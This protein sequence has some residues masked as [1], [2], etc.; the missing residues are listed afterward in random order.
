MNSII[1]TGASSMIGAATVAEALKQNIQVT[2]VIRK[3]S[4]QL[5]NL[6]HLLTDKNID[7]IE[8][9][10]QNY[11]SLSFDKK[12][13]AFFH[14]AWQSTSFERRDDVYTQI[15]NIKF[16]MDALNTAKRAGCET[17]V[18]TG[19]QAEYGRV[20][21]KLG[22]DTKCNPES[23]YGIA[24]YAAGKMSRLLASQSGIRLCYARVLSVYGEGMLSGTFIMYLIKTLLGGEKP[25][26]TKCEQLWDYMYVRDAARALLSIAEKGIDGRVYPIGSGNARPL[27]E[28]AEIIRDIINPSS[29]LGFGEK[30][31]YP[32]QPMYLCADINSLK[33]DTGFKP[34]YSFENGIKKTIEWYKNTYGV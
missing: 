11:D 21:E 17:F 8:C 4:P 26:L 13:D 31:Y 7:V 10:I 5:N 32:Y 2:A 20:A 19:S 25:S 12:Y 29:E 16:T 30:D 3:N 34:Q 6:S 22:A 33:K 18:Y 14:M 15:N 23:G 1:I 24:K 9:E 28:Y 27:R